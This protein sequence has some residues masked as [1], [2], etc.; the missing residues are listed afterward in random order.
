M[1]AIHGRCYRLL[2]IFLC[3]LMTPLPSLSQGMSSSQPAGQ[4][5]ALVPQATRNGTVATV[6]EDVMWNDMLRTEGAGRAR[7]TLKDGSMLSLG[8][9][10]ELKV[11]QHDPTSQQTEIELNY[12]TVRSHVT[13]ITKPGGK[14]QVKT[15]AAVAGVVGTDFIVI[16]VG[17]RMQVIVLKGVVQVIGLNGVILGTVNPGQMVNV[18]NGQM[19]PPMQTPPGIQQ[20]T[21]SQTNAGG[22][23]GGAAGGGAA[24]GGALAGGT[25]LHSVLAVIGAVAASSAITV[26]TANQPP[27]SSGSSGTPC[28]DAIPRNGHR[29][30]S[31]SGH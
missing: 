31:C 10:S 21:I 11:L 26:V 24:G 20:T 28:P 4:I 29:V 1:R 16:Y 27:N 23:A 9:N 13:P 6:K 30:G 7:V 3:L 17:G 8:S 22:T 15:S 18:V 25:L 5:S 19:S 14:F 2:A 12:G